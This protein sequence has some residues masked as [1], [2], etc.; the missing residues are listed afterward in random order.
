MKIALKTLQNQVVVITGASSGIGL[1]TARQAAQRGARVVMACR[2][3]EMLE[4]AAEQIRASGGQ[5]LAVQAD[6]RKP[7]DHARILAA[8]LERYG[9]V[10][11][12]INNAG[13]SIFGKL[14]EVPYEDQRALFDTNYWGVVYGS[15][16]ALG[17]LKQHGGALINVGSEVSDRAI[18]LQGAYSASKHA[19]K[20]F[21]D[22]LRMEL[23]V[24]QAPVSVTLVK[25]AS[26]ETGFTRHARNYM[27]VEPR[28]PAPLYSPEVV[29]EAILF[30]AETPR[31]D[32]FVGSAAKAVSA[33]GH[34]APALL[35][36]LA[37]TFVRQQRSNV[38]KRPE[39]RD[40]L[41]E[42]GEGIS[43]AVS[44]GRP[45]HAR[46]LY[47]E[48]TTQRQGA[49]YAGMA[50]AGA[51]AILGMFSRRGGAARHGHRPA[52]D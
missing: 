6:V 37:G 3:L 40:A 23:A 48:A 30:A 25:P 28:L 35:D 29:A 41:H 34:R 24:D 17:H 33:A 1:A 32:V 9:T 20:G 19:V 44:E 15:L 36:K 10:D 11:T 16:T 27:D 42:P 14:E 49:L 38:Q 13:V 52:W 5:A 39:R 7:E 50:L 46:S 45:V 47:T 31:R 2:N 4:Q 22:A 51:C 8:A 18:P 43:P 21:T 12:W 26:V